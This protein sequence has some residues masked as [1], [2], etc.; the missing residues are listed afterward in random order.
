MA[1]IAPTKPVTVTFPKNDVIAALVAE[2]I[3]VAKAEAQVR[4]IPLPPDAPKII[5]ASVPMD[6]LSVVDTL[7][8]LE[9][10]VGFELREAIVRTGGYSSIEAALEHLVP[11]IERVWIRKKGSKP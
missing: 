9:S 3:E 7:C 6:S 8:A 1:T 4:G 2:L 5:K 11:K 10:V